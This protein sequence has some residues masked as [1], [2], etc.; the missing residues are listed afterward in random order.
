[1]GGSGDIAPLV[2]KS[3]HWTAVVSCTPQLLCLWG[4][5]PRY[6]WDRSWKGR[7]GALDP[8]GKR[9]IS[10]PY[11]ESNHNSPDVQP[12]A[13]SLYRLSYPGS[14]NTAV[15]SEPKGILSF[16]G[17]RYL[18]ISNSGYLSSISV[19]GNRNAIFRFTQKW[20]LVPEYEEKQELHG[21]MFYRL[22]G[23]ASATV[24]AEWRQRVDMEL[25]N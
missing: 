17:G 7:T 25:H 9:Q 12:A 2:Y 5:R 15:T 20:I 1:V 3:W 13:Q 22:S 18:L 10:C 11:R 16:W 23:T 19:S 21:R 4:K 14:E 6:L 24:T 8:L